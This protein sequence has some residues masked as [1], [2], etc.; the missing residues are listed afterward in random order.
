LYRTSANRQKHVIGSIVLRL[1]GSSSIL[2][3]LGVQWP[4]S[5]LYR[6]VKFSAA[7]M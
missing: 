4:A 6:P 3:E 5:W 1:L 2:A 7:C